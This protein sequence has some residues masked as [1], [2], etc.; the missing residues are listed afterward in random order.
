MRLVARAMVRGQGKTE[1]Y[2]ERNVPLRARTVKALGS[3]AGT[4]SIGDLSRERIKQVQVVQRVLSHAIQTLPT[5]KI[6]T[7]EEPEGWFPRSLSNRS[8]G[9]VPSY[10]PATSPR[11]RR[12]PSPWP[13]DRRHQ[14]A[15]ESPR[16][17]CFVSARCSAA[18]IRQVRAAGSLE[19]L[20]VAGSSRTPFCITSRTRTIWQY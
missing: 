4:Q 11:L 14:P 6:P 1:G 2:H 9:S 15:K 10:A 18:L 8:T 5:G 19:K 20:P 16:R 13:P 17:Y 3:P 7:G 12:R